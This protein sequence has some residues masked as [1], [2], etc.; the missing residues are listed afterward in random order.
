MPQLNMSDKD[1][2]TLAEYLSMVMQH[3]AVN[4]ATTDAKQFTPAMASL[5]KQLYEV[6][7]Q[8]QSCHTIGGTGGYVGPNLN[9]AGGWL[10]AA[11]IQ[12]WLRNPQALVPDT[13]E[14]HR[15]FTDPEINAMTAYLLTLRAGIKPQTAARNAAA[16]SAV[17]GAGQ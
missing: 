9:N 15:N 1:A 2:A 3:P 12:A 13:M 6:K 4:P 5:G 14:P 11:W 16:P 17:Q 8:C 10:T 7:Y